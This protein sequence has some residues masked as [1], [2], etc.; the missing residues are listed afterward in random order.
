MGRPAITERRKRARKLKETFESFPF[1]EA[2]N[3]QG[4]L[5][6]EGWAGTQLEFFRCG[7]S[8]EVN[9]QTMPDPKL[10]QMQCGKLHPSQAG[11]RRPGGG[12]PLAAIFYSW[13]YY[14]APD[15]IVKI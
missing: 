3:F 1:M 14:T 13:L 5:F 8:P 12:G 6:S 2:G 4:S 11:S 9:S 15:G 10:A 7:V